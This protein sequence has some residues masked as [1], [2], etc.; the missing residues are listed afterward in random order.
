[1]QI[2][3]INNSPILVDMRRK[4]H[5][6]MPELGTTMETPVASVCNFAVPVYQK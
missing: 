6:L 3:G 5:E 1:M 2:I 4:Q